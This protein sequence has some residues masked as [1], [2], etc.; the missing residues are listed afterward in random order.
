V[1]Q[2]NKQL[3]LLVSGETHSAFANLANMVGVPNYTQFASQI[4]SVGL[5]QRMEEMEAEGKMKDPRSILWKAR[6]D[7]Q[8]R[9]EDQSALNE[10]Y[11]IT[12]D[13]ELLDD[14]EDVALDLGL[15]LQEAANYAAE[16]NEFISR[17]LLQANGSTKLGRCIIWLGKMFIE[18]P[19][20][21]AS[22]VG[23]A[24]NNQGFTKGMLRNARLAC[25]IQ[26]KKVNAKWVWAKSD[27]EEQSL[28]DSIG[29]PVSYAYHQTE[30]TSIVS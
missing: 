8:R 7:A 11:A 5:E 18:R 12:D 26:T 23:D 16:E 28:R 6:F 30:T 15:N 3:V 21:L 22:E 10:L 27:I 9:F 4:F 25:S 13:P 29:E 17:A 24:A 2:T 20:I 1:K 14:L 19:V